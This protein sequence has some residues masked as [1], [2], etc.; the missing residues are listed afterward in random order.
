MKPPGLDIDGTILGTTTLSRVDGPHGQLHY[1]GYDLHDLVAHATWEQVAYLLWYGDLPTP[2]QL[3]DLREQC[4][5][6][7][8][9]NDAE[10]DLLRSLPR[11]GH[12]MDGLRTA[13]SAL[14]ALHQPDLMHPQRILAEGLHL[15]AKL[16]TILATWV[17]LRNGQ[18]PVAPDP[19]LSHA[20][21][22]LLMLHGTPPDEVAARVLDTYMLILAENGLNVSTFVASVVASTRTDLYAAITAAIATLKGLSHGGAN[23]HAM[24]TFLAVGAPEHAETYLAG[25]V[26][27]KERMMGIGHRVFDVEDPRM[28]HMRRLSAEL[29]ARPDSSDTSHAV[30][31][32]MEQAIASH[33]YFQSRTLL[34]NVEFYSAPLLYQLGFPLDC[35]TAVFACAR[36]PGWVAHIREQLTQGKL[37]R[38]EADYVGRETVPWPSG[39]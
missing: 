10:L 30:A 13:V 15:T 35:F 3:A 34:P 1:C 28:R 8:G 22:F 31:Q 33:P 7:R 38:P 6:A 24:R 32:A 29:A 25:M 18:E 39:A 12:G 14:A 5:A 16:P 17:R 19:T 36:M 9:L 21:H 4:A 2:A 11:S 26:E 23:E 20:A 27:R 37:V